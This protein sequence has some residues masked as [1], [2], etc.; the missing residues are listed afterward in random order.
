[1]VRVGAGQP[2]SADR[3]SLRGFVVRHDR[4]RLRI[5]DLGLMLDR[6]VQGVV[7][8]PPPCLESVVLGAAAFDLRRPLDA[9]ALALLVDTCR[10]LLT[11]PDTGW[12]GAPWPA[13]PGPAAQRQSGRTNVKRPST[14]P[15]SKA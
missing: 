1:M 4:V 8:D 7:H 3:R 2:V 6:R 15:V 13:A 14:R 5:D 10:G 11:D 9:A 12:N